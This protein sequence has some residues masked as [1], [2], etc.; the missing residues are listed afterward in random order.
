MFNAGDLDPAFGT[1]G[2]LAGPRFVVP[3]GSIAEAVAFAGGG[4]VVV[5]GAAG[6]TADANDRNPAVARLNPDGSL[7]TTFDGDGWATVPLLSSIFGQ[8]AATAV[9]VQPDDKVLLG[10]S[11]GSSKGVFLA[12][13]NADGS[14][15]TS[16]SDDG[17]YFFDPATTGLNDVAEIK[18][19]PDGKI[20]V[21]GGM[22]FIWVARFNPDGALDTTF[23]F[24]GKTSADPSQAGNT[25]DRPTDLA[26][27]A[28]GRVVVA[29]SARWQSPDE[30]PIVVRFNTAGRLDT[31]FGGGDGVA[32]VPIAPGAACAVRAEPDGSI[33]A[34]GS[35]AFGVLLAHFLPDGTP[36]AAF[37][38]GGYRLSPDPP[39]DV[40]GQAFRSMEFMPDG[41]FVAAAPT[42]DVAGPGD[43]VF[44][45]RYLADGRP[46]ATFGAGG[47]ASAAPPQPPANAGGVAVSPLG[48]VA[49]AVLVPPAG[50]PHRQAAVAR[51]TPGGQP[52]AAFA[53]GVATASYGLA[54][55]ASLTRL[56]E[57]LD[58]K[59]L[60][61]GTLLTGGVDDPL[62]IGRFNRDGSPDASFDSDGWLETPVPG[63]FG[64]VTSFQTLPDGKMLI[65]SGRPL[66]FSGS[67]SFVLVRL[68]PDGSFDNT[69]GSGGVVATPVP[70]G[71]G[72]SSSVWAMALQPDGKIVATGPV[73][74]GHGFPPT[75]VV[76]ARYNPDGSIDAG[77]GSAGL[78][79]T[80]MDPA[81]VPESPSDVAVLSDG[82]ILL[83]ISSANKSALVRYRPDGTPDF[84]FGNQF[85]QPGVFVPPSELGVGVS[86]LLA[87]PAGAFLASGYSNPNEFAVARFRAD[88]APDP[89]FGNNGVA[90]VS[91]SGPPVSARTIRIDRQADGKI[92]LG[93]D[94]AGQS[95]QYAFAAARFNAGGSPDTTFGTGGVSVVST[96]VEPDD[97][98]LLSDGG[99]VFLSVRGPVL[100]R[101]KGDPPAALSPTARDVFYNGSAFDGHDA[102]VTPDDNAAVAT[103]KQPLRPGQAAAFAN[104][105][106]YT[107]GINGVVVELSGIPQAELLAGDFIFRSGR[108]G[109]PAGWSEGPA[110]AWVALLPAAAG[111]SVARYGI[112]WGPNAV[113][114]G[115]LQVTVKAN[116]RTGLASPDVFYFGN[117]VGETGDGSGAVMTVGAADYIQTR[118]AAGRRGAAVTS[119]FDFDR[120][121]RVDAAD[122]AAVRANWGHS[123]APP[124]SPTGPAAAVVS[125]PDRAGRRRSVYGMLVG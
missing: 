124:A 30:Q 125:G 108:T 107:K 16:F 8:A 100:A 47:E 56:A 112:I 52:D 120:N 64:G 91:V 79:V 59:L 1:G 32:M 26:V 34:A 57:S 121:G 43:R 101:L 85:N 51:F 29:G 94:M 73:S 115:W 118:A 5:A 110:P 58:G 45:R 83:A 10:G 18:V 42:V 2:I 122:L 69:F 123:L 92:V 13:F 15:D 89:A 117:L 19:L 90:R 105:T 54:Q 38:A 55:P 114:N 11:G 41:R 66:L 60:A 27:D 96:G 77:F 104:V 39:S 99:I 3:G 46:D 21:A 93:G 102:R 33:T 84:D 4:K 36:D 97:V 44:V 87:L 17:L 25:R 37:G 113:R 119:R 75:L 28:A 40:P 9:A 63:G 22:E 67:A 82:A 20:L 7:D 78:V 106:S 61:A 48:E 80:D 70:S 14:Y 81:F 62:L 53:G 109:S 76:T 65:G 88:G 68:N 74:Q 71:G 98:A 24:A 103:D 6:T 116:A 35:S 111:D 72:T 12:R 31:T 23:G 86:H 49:V 50:G 95:G